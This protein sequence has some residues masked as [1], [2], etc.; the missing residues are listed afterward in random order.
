MKWRNKM[1]NEITIMFKTWCMIMSKDNIFTVIIKIRD[2]IQISNWFCAWWSQTDFIISH[3]DSFSP[4]VIVN[5]LS[6]GSVWFDCFWQGA[7]QCCL[8]S[9]EDTI[10]FFG[11]QSRREI[12]LTMRG[13][14]YILSA[15]IICLLSIFVSWWTSYWS[16]AAVCWQLHEK[17]HY[18]D[19]FVNYYVILYCWIR[20]YL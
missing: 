9:K 8:Y 19:C 15:R 4:F 17:I 1:H 16:L 10:S 5:A 20:I 3:G 7:D 6:V 18:L 14:L 13:L 2:T 11:H 12:L